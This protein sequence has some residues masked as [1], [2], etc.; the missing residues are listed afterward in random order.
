MTRLAALPLLAALA[1]PAASAPAVPLSSAA[2]R[3]P[4]ELVRGTLPATPELK[5]APWF[6]ERLEYE[7]QWGVFTVGTADMEARRVVDFNGQPAVQL[8]SRAQSNKFC[9]AFYK[10]RDLNES[11]IHARDFRSLGYSK[12]LRE[13]EFF[14]DEWVLYDYPSRSWLSRT[15]NKDG[16]SAYRSGSIPGAVQDILSSLYYIRGKP[17]EVGSEITLDVNTRENWPLVV[18]VLRRTRAKVP[19]GDF[20]CVLVEP[21]LRQEGIFVQKGKRMRVWLTDDAR[22]IP[23]HLSVDVFFG[24]VTASLTKI[25]R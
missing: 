18:K 12:R 21:F 3:E 4:Y 2:V 25:E 5:T 23:V 20:P 14:R 13:G 8:V 19:A 7:V 10:V 1:A 11:W 17:L 6:A 24:S 22:R 16:S 15:T 9:D